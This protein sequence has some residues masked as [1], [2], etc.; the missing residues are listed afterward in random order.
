MELTR[1]ASEYRTKNPIAKVM[2][3]PK[4]ADRRPEIAPI[5]A[6]PLA[7]TIPNKNNAHIPAKNV[8]SSNEKSRRRVPIASVIKSDAL[9]IKRTISAAT[10]R[11]VTYWNRLKGKVKSKSAVPSSSSSVVS[12]APQLMATAKKMSGRAALNNSVER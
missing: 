10:K 4:A 3:V 11:V 8:D 9:I 5:K 6:A 1:G 2:A 7:K 12:L